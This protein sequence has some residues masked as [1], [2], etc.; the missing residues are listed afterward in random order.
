MWSGSQGAELFALRR[1]YPSDRQRAVW[2]RPSGSRLRLAPCPPDASEG[3]GQLGHIFLTTDSSR[4]ASS[5]TIHR[6]LW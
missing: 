3:A 4:L 2:R 6:A 5:K 1:S